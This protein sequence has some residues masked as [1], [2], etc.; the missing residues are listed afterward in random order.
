MDVV[1]TNCRAYCRTRSGSAP[2]GLRMA[3]LAAGLVLAFAGPAAAQHAD[4]GAVR[5]ET[6]DVARFLATLDALAAASTYRDSAA[7]LFERYYLPATP[8]LR[9][10]IRLRIGSPFELLDQIA[11]H[12]AYYAHLP[13]SLAGL[14]AAEP[15]IR[16]AFRRFAA[17]YPEAVFADTYFLIGRMNSGGT[18][19]PGRLLIGAEMYGLDEDAPAHE[20]GEWHRAVLRDRSILVTIA[21][22]E[23]M[24]VNQPR[25]RQNT[26][27]AQS[28]REG[29]ADFL[30]ELVTGRNINEHVHAWANP[31]EQELWREFS[32]AMHGTDLNGWFFIQDGGERPSDLGYWMGYRIVKAY[33]DRAADRSRAIGEILN[34]DD[35]ADFLQRSGYG[36]AAGLSSR[37]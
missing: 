24:H 14:L 9:D 34:I 11:S 3:A 20:L 33:Y 31:R 19:S 5:I 17:L 25:T 18:I 27:L 29:S 10:F 6:S 23:L 16:A 35:P 12:R 26:L 37:R 15:D 30:A 21:V 22:H 13:R 4:P 32:A 1:R 8:G 28:L 7:I 36:A 2:H